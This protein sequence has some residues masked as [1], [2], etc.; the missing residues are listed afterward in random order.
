MAASF[1]SAL[2]KLLKATDGATSDAKGRAFEELACFLFEAVPGV[3]VIHRRALNALGSEE[4]DIALRNNKYRDGLDFLESFLLVECKNW[5]SPVGSAEVGTFVSKLRHRG[6]D[7]GIL[8]AASGITG[9]A[10]DGNR[11]HQQ[12]ALALQEKIR[13]IVIT[14]GEIEAL[15]S[16]GDLVSL[17]IAKVGQLIATGNVWL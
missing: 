3:S 12:V 15:K 14:R 17:I 4:I 16:G 1:R 13:L 8:I 9:N 2:K 5:S 11:A 6:L 10:G 7:F